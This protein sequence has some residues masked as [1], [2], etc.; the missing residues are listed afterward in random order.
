MDEGKSKKM[1]LA[2]ILLVFDFSGPVCSFA[3]IL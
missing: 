3:V 1:D 2:K